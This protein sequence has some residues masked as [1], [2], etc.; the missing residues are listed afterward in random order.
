MDFEMNIQE[1]RNAFLT[2]KIKFSDRLRGQPYWTKSHEIGNQ[3]KMQNVFLT[4]GQ[5]YYASLV[6]ANV[7]LFQPGLQ[8]HGAEILFS[9]DN[10]FDAQPLRL[11]EIARE[12]FQYKNKDAKD[13]PK[14]LADIISIISNEHKY[15]FNVKVPTEITDG[16]EVFI[17]T[18]IIH[19][20]HLPKRKLVSGLFPIIALP[21]KVNACMVL[22]KR[23]WTEEMKFLSL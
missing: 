6:Q 12:L 7:A 13:I 1:M 3:Y 10:Y 17:T 21:D 16:R 2:K 22:P 9:T 23:F 4:Q 19:R 15:I 18:L 11:R 5:V 14:H 8:N 20:H